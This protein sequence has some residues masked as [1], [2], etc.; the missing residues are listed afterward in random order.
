MYQEAPAFTGGRG[1]KLVQSWYWVLSQLEAPAFTG[2]RGL[3]HAKTGHGA[4]IDGKRPPSRA[5]ED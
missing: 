2:G 3:K 4:V 1:L 5:G